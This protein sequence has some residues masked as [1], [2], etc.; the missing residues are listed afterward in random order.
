MRYYL[1][2][3]FRRQPKTD[4]YC[5]VC[6]RDLKDSNPSKVYLG[7]GCMDAIDK[8]EP[9]FDGVTGFIGPE[10]RARVPEALILKL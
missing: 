2:P 3:D 1:N 10:C 8:H 5:C 9:D 6:G 7:E 4:T